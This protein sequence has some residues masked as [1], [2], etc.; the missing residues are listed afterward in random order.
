MILKLRASVG[1]NNKFFELLLRLVLCVI[2]F[3]DTKLIYI[4][5]TTLVGI[6]KIYANHKRTFIAK[7]MQYNFVEDTNYCLFFNWYITYY[8]KRVVGSNSRYLREKKIITNRIV[9]K[10]YI[11]FLLLQIIEFRLE[12]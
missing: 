11:V 8:V 5:T 6:Y 3:F 2:F 4:F 7:L 9:H 10:I 1:C 12:L